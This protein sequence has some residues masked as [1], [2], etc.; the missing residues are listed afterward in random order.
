[1]KK[2]DGSSIRMNNPY[3]RIIYLNGYSASLFWCP[4]GISKLTSS[5][6][7]SL[8]SL[9]PNLCYPKTA[10][11]FRFLHSW[12]TVPIWS[13]H[14]Y[15]KQSWFISVTS[16]GPSHQKDLVAVLLTFI[17]NLTISIEH[18]PPGSL[19]SSLTWNTVTVS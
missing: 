7:K 1:M 15:K 2:L 12:S 18:W 9:A 8:L 17:P 4:I 5:K 19:P 14:K 13:Q 10:S 3:S 11:P 16:H 6:Q